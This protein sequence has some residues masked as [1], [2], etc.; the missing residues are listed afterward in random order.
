MY[1]RPVLPQAWRKSDDTVK[2]VGYVYQFGDVSQ[3]F[4]LTCALPHVRSC[5]GRK[6]SGARWSTDVGCSTC[7][8]TEWEWGMPANVVR[9]AL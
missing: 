7:H 9:P 5:L 4:T 2:G 1:A 8:G 3:V 6:D